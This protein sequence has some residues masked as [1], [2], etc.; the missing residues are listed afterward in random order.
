[1]AQSLF[2]FGWQ[3]ASEKDDKIYGAAIATVIDNLDLLCEARVQV[4]LPWAPGFEPWARVATMMA[5]S[6]RGSFFIPQVGDE[7]VVV[8][9]HGDMR[10]PFVV[11]ALWNTL[12]KPP[13]PLATDAINKRILRT[14]LGQK[15]V[16]D[17]LQQSITIGNELQYQL[18]LGSKSSDLKSAGASVSLDLVGNVTIKGAVSIKLDAPS[19]KIS[20][21]N[22]SISGSAG[23]TIDGGL[24]CT[25]SGAE[26]NIG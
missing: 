26:V 20:G 18:G 8:F 19:I 4:S 11:G 25:I 21:E 24:N 13:A 23:A 2:E 9:N 10:E 3:P 15:I 12:D 22:I 5:G 6:Q 17:D 7:V 14:P 1:M 16:F